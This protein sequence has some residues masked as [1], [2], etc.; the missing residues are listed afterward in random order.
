MKLGLSR[1]C[2]D[3]TPRFGDAT[4]AP[5]GTL[6]PH[7]HKGGIMILMDGGIATSKYESGKLGRSRIFRS[8]DLIQ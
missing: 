6:H 8:S 7:T 4:C 5:S 1:K 2:R 3:E